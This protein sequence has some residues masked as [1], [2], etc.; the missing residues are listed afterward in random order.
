MSVTASLHFHQ[1][2]GTIW[3]RITDGESLASLEVRNPRWDWQAHCIH[4]DV[5]LDSQ[6]WRLLIL[7]GFQLQLIRPGGEA[8]A[9]WSD[10]L[11]RYGNR[12]DAGVSNG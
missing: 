11:E 8:A 6:V 5:V 2:G 3:L 7:S 12:M 1:C 4:A 10:L 9:S